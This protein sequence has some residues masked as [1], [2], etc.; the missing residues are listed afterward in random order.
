MRTV[1]ISVNCLFSTRSEP[2][3]SLSWAIAVGIHIIIGGSIMTR[4]GSVIYGGR[5]DGSVFREHRDEIK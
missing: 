5:I 1:L 2:V 3:S 4:A